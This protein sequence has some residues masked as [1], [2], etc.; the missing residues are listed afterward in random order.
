M[1]SIW[2]LVAVVAKPRLGL[3]QF[4]EDSRRELLGALKTNIGHLEAAA[5][6]SGFI[7]TVMSV[8]RGIIPGNLHFQNPN[9]HIPF[10]QLRVKVV[11]AEQKWPETGRPRRA[12][13]SS[14]GF[15]GTNGTLV[16]RRA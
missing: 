9:P 11:A 13:V 16:F 4:L 2:A 15:G 8:N 14:F 5:G 3:K 7:K 6:I 1:A 10:D 12:G